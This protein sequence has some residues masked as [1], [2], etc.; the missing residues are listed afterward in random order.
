[1]KVTVAAAYTSVSTLDVEIPVNSWD[2][3]EYW[4]VKWG[5]LYYKVK[6]QEEQV[7]VMPEAD[8]L[9]MKRPGSVEVTG[10]EGETLDEI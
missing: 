2:E 1:M 7:V 10:E 9:D 4:H 3:L 6:D 8:T 5:S